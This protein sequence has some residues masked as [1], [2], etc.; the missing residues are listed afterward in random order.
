[1]KVRVASTRHGIGRLETATGLVES[2]IGPTRLTNRHVGTRPRFGRTPVRR[3]RPGL[4]RIDSSGQLGVGRLALVGLRGEISLQVTDRS[5]LREV[6]LRA[7]GE[8]NLDHRIA[9]DAAESPTPS[10]AVRAVP[11]PLR[12]QVLLALPARKP[13][14]ET[15]VVVVD[16]DVANLALFP[17]LV[18]VDVAPLD[19]DPRTSRAGGIAP[20]RPAAAKAA[21]DEQARR[22]PDHDLHV[23]S[24][25]VPSGTCSYL[26]IVANW[27][28]RA[29]A[30]P[31][32][33]TILPFLG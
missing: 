1:M 24:S 29:A 14:V 21:H 23:S 33:G 11:A 17:N 2:T 28:F 31:P 22:Q 4:S 26:S 19:I 9:S 16:R 13:T 5:V 10:V 7:F 6:L 3:I 20:Q 25:S 27:R 12:D 8:V 30:H 32:P 15:G 18:A